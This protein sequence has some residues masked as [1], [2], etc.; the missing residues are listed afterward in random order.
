MKYSL[1]SLVFTIAAGTQQT[2]NAAGRFFTVKEATEG[3]FRLGVDDGKLVPWDTGMG[4]EVAQDE[5]GFR[6]LTIENTSADPITFTILVGNGHVYD[7]RLNV[8]SNR[9][10]AIAADGVDATGITPP[11]GGSGIRGWLSGIYERLDGSGGIAQDGTDADG[12]VAPTGGVGIRGWLSGIYDRLSKGAKTVAN[13][14]SFTLASDHPEIAVDDATAAGLLTANGTFLADLAAGMN[15]D[16]DALR[17]QGVADARQSALGSII[18]ELSGSAGTVTTVNLPDYARGM[19]LTASA[20]SRF[21]INEDPAPQTTSAGNPIQAAWFN[22]GNVLVANEAE[23]RALP[24]GTGR[25]LRLSST[26]AS[27]TV[28]VEVF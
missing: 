11:A 27:A 26:T 12:I 21:A 2:L 19:R 18:V 24:S 3:T 16:G 14:L 5:D 6:S 22:A 13:S 4:Y 8:V 1:T 25:T 10:G 28:T 17:V 23:T 7:Q 9:T 15:A 20:L